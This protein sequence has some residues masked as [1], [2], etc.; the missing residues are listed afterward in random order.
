[1]SEIDV[2][3]AWA[4]L[5][6]L[7]RNPALFRG[8]EALG[9]DAEGAL[10]ETFQTSRRLAVRADYGWA[11]ADEVSPAV[12]ALLDLYLP[13]ASASADRP[14]TVAHLGQSLDGYIATDSGDS[15]YVTGP[16]NVLHLHRMRALCG[17]VI[18]G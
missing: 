14:L 3:E 11:A 13:I 15:Y 4:G 7:S 2:D 9:L 6:A 17:A 10:T 18:V 12:R 5:V 1:V 8:A 16:D